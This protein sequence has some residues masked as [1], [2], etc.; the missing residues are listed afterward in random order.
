[1]AN[2]YQWAVTSMTAYPQYEE[3]TDVVF[4]VAWVCSGTNGTDNAAVYGS[5][6]LTL[7]PAAPFTPY[8]DLTLDQ[9][10]GWVF[11]SIGVDGKAAAELECDN[12]IAAM[13]APQTVM[14]PLPWNV[15]TPAPEPTP[16]E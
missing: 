3:Q 6:D 7:D 10:L 14:P 12:L 13:T 5:V 16:V 11:G 9:V 15:P 4:Q 8:A 2:T 1:M